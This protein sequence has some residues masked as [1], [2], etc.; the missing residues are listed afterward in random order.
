[1]GGVSGV[2]AIS[3]GAS[4][5]SDCQT[6]FDGLIWARLWNGLQRSSTT[7]NMIV[8]KSAVRL[9]RFEE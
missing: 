1:M 2:E 6:L 8:S 9:R 4:Q 7:T 5:A 3:V